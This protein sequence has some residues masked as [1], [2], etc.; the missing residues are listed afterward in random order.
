MDFI[1]DNILN[2]S[3]FLTTCI[4]MGV[5]KRVISKMILFWVSF[6]RR[7]PQHRQR[8]PS[9]KFHKHFNGR[10]MHDQ[11]FLAVLTGG[12]KVCYSEVCLQREYEPESYSCAPLRRVFTALGTCAPGQAVPSE[13]QSARE[14]SLNAYFLESSKWFFFW[15]RTI[16]S[17]SNSLI[18]FHLF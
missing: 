7:D 15:Q 10:E 1:K 6:C 16:C 8:N 5:L 3:K 9:T 17:Y 18:V 13:R 12:M 4:L 2:V 14:I 11:L